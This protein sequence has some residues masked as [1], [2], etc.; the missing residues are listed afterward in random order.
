MKPDACII[1]VSRAEI[2]ERRALLEALRSGRLGGLGLDSLYEEPG[3]SDDE[4][5]VVRECHIDTSH[6]RFSTDKW[7]QGY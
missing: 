5:L 6:G 3:R 2:I 1:N 7:A 4:L